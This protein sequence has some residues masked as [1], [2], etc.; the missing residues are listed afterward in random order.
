MPVFGWS[1]IAASLASLIAQILDVTY[2]LCRGLFS[3]IARQPESSNT[4]FCSKRRKRVSLSFR[5]PRNPKFIAIPV[6]HR[7]E[8][9][10]Q[11]GETGL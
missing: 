2:L 7:S 4:L 10:T 1:S 9:Q 6:P 8:R 5:D 11:T 3:V